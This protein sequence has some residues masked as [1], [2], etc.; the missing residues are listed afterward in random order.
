MRR[1][2]AGIGAAI[3]MVASASGAAADVT[4]AA[5]RCGSWVTLG[6]GT[7]VFVVE[8]CP[9][10]DST[11]TGNPG[12]PVG[13]ANGD[14]HTSGD[15]SSGPP[16]RTV[17]REVYNRLFD[18]CRRG[19]Y[20]DSLSIQCVA[21][22]PDVIEDSDPGTPGT[23]PMTL[24][25]VR[26]VAIARINMGAP[27]IGASPCLATPGA[28]RGTVGVP[29]WLWVGDGTG[30]LPSES[31]TVSAGPFTITAAAKVSK[32]KWSLGDG[33]STTCDG[34]GTK[35]DPQRDGWS[36]PPCGFKAGWKQSGTQTLTATYVW[37]ITWSG[38]DTGS[39][40][41]SLS[42]TEQVTVGELQSVATTS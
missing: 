29:V 20:G 1:V 42:S 13:N 14:S 10:E 30:A 27:E 37:E 5:K 6:H 34:V 19:P 7:S 11:G 21:A 9:T 36:A 31:A 28:C 33:Q 24:T 40:T 16:R 2:I 12:G 39:A 35:Y 23:P 4:A 18:N 15:G 8:E 38:S 32:V 22:L 25:Q 17:T 26:E 41:Q 3:V